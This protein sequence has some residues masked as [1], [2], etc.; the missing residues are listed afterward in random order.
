MP[1]YQEELTR[2][3]SEF[4]D[5]ISPGQTPFYVPYEPMAGEPPKECFSIVP[6]KIAAEGGEHVIGWGIHIA[7]H[8]WLEAEFHAIWQRPDGS[9]VDITPREGDNGLTDVLF[10]PDPT[11]KYEGRQVMPRYQPLTENP[12]VLR[13]IELQHQFFRK[14]NEGDLANQNAYAL[15]REHLLI[16][17]EMQKLR[18]N[19]AD[20]LTPA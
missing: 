13:L 2:I 19:I 15:T 7:E 12:D 4:C 11:R 9:L 6:K 8:I 16:L 1:T 18:N 10:L 3:A 14:T 17:D 20:S 5:S